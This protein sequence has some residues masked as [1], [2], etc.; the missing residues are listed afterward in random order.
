[1]TLI[2][3]L[4]IKKKL[5]DALNHIADGIDDNLQKSNKQLREVHDHAI[6]FNQT[7]NLFLEQTRSKDKGT[8]EKIERTL[9]LRI[10]RQ[11]DIGRTITRAKRKVFQLVTKLFYSDK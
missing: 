10:E 2:Q 3:H 1:M 6:E 11:R 4:T 9:R 7:H 8:T 5:R